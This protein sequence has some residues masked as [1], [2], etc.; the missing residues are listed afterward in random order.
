MDWC[1]E[2]WWWCWWVGAGVGI[3]RLR[4]TAGHRSQPVG[5]GGG[6]VE[7]RLCL[8]S[9]PSSGCCCESLLFGVLGW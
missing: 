2:L 9:C 8:L 3:A 1:L 6:L 7:D 4:E 5:C